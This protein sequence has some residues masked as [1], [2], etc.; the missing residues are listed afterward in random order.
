[1]PNLQVIVRSTD[2]KPCDNKLN[3]ENDAALGLSATET[4]RNTAATELYGKAFN[5]LSEQQKQLTLLKMVEDANALSGALGQAERESETW[6]NQLGNMKQSLQ[7]LKAAAGSTFLKPAI[8]VLKI[9]SGLLQKATVKINSMSG[10]I[11]EKTNVIT[12]KLKEVWGF[13]KILGEKAND[14]AEKFGGWEKILKILAIAGGLVASVFAFKKIQ[15]G[16]KGIMKLLNPATLKIM[17]IVAVVLILA[18]IIED[19]INF[20]QGNDSVIG[21]LFEKAGIDADAARQKIL[22]TWT[23]IKATLSTVWEG[24]KRV[25][26]AVFGLL[27]KFWSKWGGTI[28]QY[29]S[30]FWNMLASLIDPFLTALNG[31]LT[32]IEGVFSGNWTQA[33]EGLKQFFQ[34]WIQWIT[35]LVTGLWTMW[36]NLASDLFGPILEK[37]KSGFENVKAWFQGL[38]DMA[39]QWMVDFVQGMIEGIQEKITSFTDTVMGIGEKIASFLHFSVPDKGPLTDYESWMPDFMQGMAQ[40]IKNNMPL[41]Q[42]AVKDASELLA[43]MGS[44][45]L[46]GKTALNA[47]GGNTKTNNVNQVNE[48]NIN[49]TGTDTQAV[50]KAANT[51]RDAGGDNTSS[52]AD[53]LAYGY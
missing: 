14:V 32:F 10:T 45:S 37:I 21:S 31:L 26:M 50:N 44:V 5:D 35:N 46:N 2:K 9:M 4:T 41:I 30:D 7:D 25:A 53:A 15:S 38:P 42:S 17:A 23:H 43:S 1:M 22:D 52:L 19:F 49:V 8:G 11:E 3:Y 27:Q 47:V 29:F 13:L 24:I 39:K 18:A 28:T 51:I 40:G 6:T 12:R 34:G 48:Y 36:S 33:L 20:M 16:I